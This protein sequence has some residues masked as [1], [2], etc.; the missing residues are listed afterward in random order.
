MNTDEHGYRGARGFSLV[1][2]LVVMAIL[3]VLVAIMN[4]RGSRSYQQQR[5]AV[6]EKNLQT[7]YT[8]LTLYTPDAKSRFPFVS[9]AVTS[10]EPLSLLV[11]R[12]TTV[13]EIFIC[14]GSKDAMLPSGE[15]F[16]ERK[17]SYAYYMGMDKTA[18]SGWVLITDRQVD[19]SQKQPGG[20][21]F[22]PDGKMPGNNHDR[23]GGNVLMVD[24][25]ISSTKAKVA[26]GLLFP[27]NVILLNPKP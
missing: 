5:M 26:G 3:V 4:N 19:T 7:M 18:G 13:T 9:N 8:A 12:C 22:S 27:T 21:M 6:C 25:S 11:P 16:A 17:I 14:P 1:E 20:Q 10:E 2:L 15:S 23:F 24:G